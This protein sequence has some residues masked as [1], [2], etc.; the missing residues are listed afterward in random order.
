MLKYFRQRNKRR[1]HK[2]DEGDI[3]RPAPLSIIEQK[4]DSLTAIM[5]KQATYIAQQQATIAR[6]EALLQ[7]LLDKADGPQEGY[8]VLGDLEPDF[9]Y[10]A[11]HE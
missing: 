7:R 5:E 6:Q 4:V 1:R 10:L 11:A 3:R 2:D 8:Q 9:D